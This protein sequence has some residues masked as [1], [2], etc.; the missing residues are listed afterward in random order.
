MLPNRKHGIYFFLLSVTIFLSAS[1][2][3]GS[4]QSDKPVKAYQGPE[5]PAAQLATIQC[6]MG[7][8]ITA[9]D[10]KEQYFCDPPG[11]IHVLPGEHSFDVWLALS[12]SEGTLRSRKVKRVRFKP[13]AG[14]T[15][16][17][18]AIDDK[19][20]KYKKDGWVVTIMD[21]DLSEKGEGWVLHPD[22]AIMGK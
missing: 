22:K 18:S 5:R 6:F 2:T 9:V 7:A 13:T 8:K 19:E 20:D 4:M 12:I 15:Y 17:I 16:M 10:G 3:A 14:H 11:K 21:T 1:A